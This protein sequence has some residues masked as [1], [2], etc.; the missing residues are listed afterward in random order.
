MPGFLDDPNWL[1][2][3][4]LTLHDINPEP[5]RE[6]VFHGT[7]K[8]KERFKWSTTLDALA[9]LAVHE[10]TQQIVALSAAFNNHGH[11]ELYVAQDD[12]D[13]PSTRVVP[14]LRDICAQLINVRAAIN[15]SPDPAT[16]LD[17]LSKDPHLSKHTPDPILA[18]LLDL[19]KGLHQYSILHI[20]ALFAEGSSEDDF[21]YLAACIQGP[22]ANT[23]DDMSEDERFT[24]D[25]IQN[26]E[27]VQA[28]FPLLYRSIR[29][30]KECVESPSS[31]D[32]NALCSATT[33]IANL[34]SI[35][36]RDIVNFNLLIR[37]TVYHS[38]VP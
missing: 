30:L 18:P 34:I 5:R 23:R 9:R 12:P 32:L 6:P 22:L 24:L 7:S 38:H 8:R 36:R 2:A 4:A 19:Q 33:A 21:N 1:S 3:L 31:A 27:S 20:R 37:G 11:V 17:T 25:F 26:T 29:N 28:H 10:P 13:E 14:H 35:L 15:S 16:L